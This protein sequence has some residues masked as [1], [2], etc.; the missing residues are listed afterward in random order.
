MVETYQQL[1][2]PVRLSVLLA[3]VLHAELEQDNEE[4]W[5]DGSG[6]DT[7]D[8]EEDGEE[9]EGSGKPRACCCM[10]THVFVCVQFATL[11]VEHCEQGGG[12]LR[13]LTQRTWTSWKTCLAR[14]MLVR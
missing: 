10:H 6:V 2:L 7:E 8:E 3:R 5:D 12:R 11:C 1:P 9:H 13:L 4:E 14:A